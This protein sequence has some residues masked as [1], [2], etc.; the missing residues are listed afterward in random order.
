MREIGL[1][2]FAAAP[3]KSRDSVIGVLSLISHQRRAFDQADLN[4]LVSIGSQLAVAIENARLY[5][6]SLNQVR[7]LMCL[8]EIA[9]AINLSQSLS[10]T[11]S[12]I[13]ESICNTLDY[14][15]GRGLFVR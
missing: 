4:L 12:G 14:A 15:A 11:L 2:S 13:A 5:G 3:I 7:E 9:R 10:Q 1:R 6:T 8:A